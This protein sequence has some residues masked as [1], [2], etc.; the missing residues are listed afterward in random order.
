MIERVFNFGVNNDLSG[1]LTLPDKYNST[2]PSILFLNAGFLH[3]TGFNRF[4]TELARNLS[5][6][7]FSSFRFDLHGLGDSGQCNVVSSYDDLVIEDIKSAINTISQTL[8]SE[9]FVVIGLCSGADYAH[10]AAT[11]EH[12]ITGLILLDGYAYPTLGFYLR[13]YGPGILKPINVIRFLI[14]RFSKF[15]TSSTASTTYTSKENPIYIRS[16]PDKKKIMNDIQNFI[17]R[18]VELFYIY[19]G[20]IPIYYNYSNQFFDMFRSL[21]N[22]HKISHCYLEEADHTYTIVSIRQK[23]MALITDWLINKYQAG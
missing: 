18:Q 11:L 15:L 1:I 9:R 17:D 19:S 3:K 10:L 5:D 20:G 16:F 4:N 8:S 13:D 12:R 2:T 22:K 23:L 14:N 21:K 7:G 6:R